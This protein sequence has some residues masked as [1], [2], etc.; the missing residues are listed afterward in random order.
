M[1]AIKVTYWISTGLLSALMLMSA[2]MYF[3]NHSMVVTSSEAGHT[4]PSGLF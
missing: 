1:K 4:R 3:F 2:G